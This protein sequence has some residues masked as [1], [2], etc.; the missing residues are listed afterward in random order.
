M[1]ME[2]RPLARPPVV[3]TEEKKERKK[4]RDKVVEYGTIV[5]GSGNQKGKEEGERGRQDRA[6]IHN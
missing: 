2:T 5:K 3:K 6:I 4:E 1:M